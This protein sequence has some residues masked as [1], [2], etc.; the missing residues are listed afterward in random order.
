MIEYARQHPGAVALLDDKNARK[1]A[2]AL[3]IP[4][5]GTLGLVARAVSHGHLSTFEDAA[6]RLKDA[7][8]YLDEGVVQAVRQ[9]LEKHRPYPKS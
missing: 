1:A 6:R 2:V 9:A 8:L 3:H 5:L 4:V 7:G